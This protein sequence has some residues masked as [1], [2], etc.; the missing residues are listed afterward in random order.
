MGKSLDLP[1]AILGINLSKLPAP[2]FNTIEKFTARGVLE[3][4]I[5]VITRFEEL[6]ELHLEW[7]SIR[8]GAF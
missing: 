1:H 6:V 4:D 7:K 8:S 3:R 5:V 2:L